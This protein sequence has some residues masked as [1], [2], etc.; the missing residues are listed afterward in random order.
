LRPRGAQIIGVFIVALLGSAAY[1]ADAS[2]ALRL[3]AP[4]DD[5]VVSRPPLLRWT[6]VSAATH[7][8]V[9]LWRGN[10][11]VLSRWP[12]RPRLQLHRSWH[13][14][15]RSYRL[16]SARYRWYVW[17]GFRWGYG[18]YRRRDFIVGRLPANRVRPVIAGEPREGQALTASTGA[19]RG[20]R[21]LRFSYRWLL[22]RADGS[23]CTTIP[24]AT[25]ATL[26]LGPEDIDATVRVVVTA[27]N[28]AGSRS[29]ASAATA[30]VLP[31]RPVSVS[32]PTL[33]G[34][35]QEGRLV[36]AT[37]G[38]WQSSRPVRFTFRW[39]R[40]EQGRRQC[41]AIAGARAAG[42]ILRRA[43]FGERVRV[44]VL[45]VNSGGATEAASALSPVVGRVI[46]GTPAGELLRGTVGADV[47]RA[48]AG[49][50]RVVGGFGPDRLVGGRGNDLLIA[51]V[52]D[53]IVYARDGRSDRVSCGRGDDVAF[54][55]RQDRA[56]RGCESVRAR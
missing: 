6:A 47:L 39:T 2:A 33:A 28:L 37:P 16:S 46:V 36:T 11:K 20:T 42:Y 5:A 17:P 9:Q 21:P 29:A 3:L 38:R 54:V 19:W 10:R 25:S 23:T 18:S 40:C 55:D 1:H 49:R 27:T 14:R 45:A 31:A 32:A 50:D 30:V 34:G 44:I 48:R 13:F 8:N 15:G 22:C 35:F 56:R 4:R 51:A 12:D 41:H 53:D 43:D 26:L 7:Y 52:G 24:G